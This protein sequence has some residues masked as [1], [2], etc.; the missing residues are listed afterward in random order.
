MLKTLLEF[1]NFTSE[2][3]KENHLI[4]VGNEL[5]HNFHIISN[6]QSYIITQLE[7][8]ISQND[9]F[10]SM[11]NS[12][13]HPQQMTCGKFYIHKSIKNNQ[14][15]SPKHIGIDITCGKE[16]Q[17]YG[18]LL[19]RAILNTQNQEEII[20]PSKVLNTLIN[21]KNTLNEAFSDKQKLLLYTIDGSDIFSNNV[22]SLKKLQ[23]IHNINRDIQFTNSNT[24]IS[25]K[26]Y[27]YIQPN[28]E[29]KAA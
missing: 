2:Q 17:R 19:I 25:P 9:N 28:K 26:S 14:L 16:F 24:I 12:H 29:P 5:F 6:E 11:N 4:N 20:G 13:R 22:I 3:E 27:K 15:R 8:F 23:N 10:G 1:E 7:L 18:G 21:N